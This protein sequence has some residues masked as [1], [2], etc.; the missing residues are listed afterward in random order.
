[1]VKRYQ[2]L[3]TNKALLYWYKSL[4]TNLIEAIISFKPHL[5]IDTVCFNGMVRQPGAYYINLASPIS[6][7]CYNEEAKEKIQSSSH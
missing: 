3:K 5:T 2:F 7:C 1:M 4:D 6:H